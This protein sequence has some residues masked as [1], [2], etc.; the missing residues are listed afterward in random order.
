MATR[1]RRNLHGVV[2]R[3]E[4]HRERDRAAVRVRDDPGVLEGSL[5]VHLGATSGTP[6]RAG[7]R[8]T[9]RRR[10][11]PQRP[12]RHEP[13]GS[14]RSRRRRSRRRGRRRRARPASPPRSRTA[15]PAA[16]GAPGRERADVRVPAGKEQLERDAAD[17]AA[18]AHDADAEAAGQP[19]RAPRLRRASK[20]S[21]S[22]RT[23]RSTASR[24]DVA[25]DPDRR[26]R[27]DHG[28]DPVLLE[29]GERR[30]RD[31]RWLLIPAPTMLTLPSSRVRR[32]ARAEA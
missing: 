6:G 25:A 30:R 9:C 4:R 27:D 22:A 24:S 5:A 12:R 14:S 16:R 11:R 32:P 8:R 28:L 2:E 10:A 3:R 13:R 21:C 23:A 17:R 18:D 19:R 29:R 31:A 1:T 20:A 26:G 15:D 7:T